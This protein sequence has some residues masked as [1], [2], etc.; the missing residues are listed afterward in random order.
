MPFRGARI[1]HRLDNLILGRER[2]GDLKRKRARRCQACGDLASACPGG[3][4]CGTVV[5]WHICAPFSGFGK[6]AFPNSIS[7]GNNL[8]GE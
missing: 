7:Q 3:G 1:V 2:R 8:T 5:K 6:L 4:L